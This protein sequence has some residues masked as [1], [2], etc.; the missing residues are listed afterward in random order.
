VLW[1]PAWDPDA[2][3]CCFYLLARDFLEENQI[4]DMI[5]SS[6]PN[7]IHT[8]LGAASSRAAPGEECEK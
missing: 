5:P 3:G 4:V 1:D 8:P 6:P 7:P 2:N